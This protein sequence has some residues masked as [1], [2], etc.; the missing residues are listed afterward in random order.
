VQRGKGVRV[1]SGSYFLRLAAR[2]FQDTASVRLGLSPDAL[3]VE[4]TSCVLACLLENQTRL[5]LG[6]GDVPILL[7]FK[8]LVAAQI[9]RDR[10]PH[11]IDNVEQRF[12]F[13]SDRTAKRHAA[14]LFH[15][16]LKAIYEL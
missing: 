5:I 16:L 8:L 1:R 3:L 4:Q 11:L 7:R 2:L 6:L 9:L 15:K 13:D 14:T 10:D 12:A